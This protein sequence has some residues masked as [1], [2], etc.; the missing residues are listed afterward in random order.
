MAVHWR[1]LFARTT[2]FSSVDRTEE[3]VNGDN[4]NISI[5]K[6]S[7][8]HSRQYEISLQPHST[9]SVFRRIEGIQERTSPATADYVIQCTPGVR[10]KGVCYPGM[11]RQGSVSV[12]VCVLAGSETS[13]PIDTVTT[14]SSGLNGHWAVGFS[15]ML[16]PK[17]VCTFTLLATRRAKAKG[18][19]I[20]SSLFCIEGHDTGH[21]PVN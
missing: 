7:I 3:K 14:K 17:G 19:M 11:S 18:L 4:G 1:L 5:Q 6:A 12:V 9:S 21:A 16:L 2:T 20:S 13:H 10:Q 8:F 15:P